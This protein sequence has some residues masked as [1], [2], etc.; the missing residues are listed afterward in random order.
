MT[1]TRIQRKQLVRQLKDA[2][3][4][5]LYQ[6]TLAVLEYDRGKSIAE[7]ARTLRVHRRSVHRWLE[8]YREAYDPATLVDEARSGRPAHWTDECSEWLH[9]FLR[10]NPIELGYFAANW[11]VP[12]LRDAFELGV[13]RTISND[14]IRRALVRFGYVWKRP[15]Y[16]LEPDPE[17]EKKTKYSSRNTPF[18]RPERLAG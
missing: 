12:L 1:L 13:G 2:R 3:N 9:S 15:R 11:T 5:R 8:T 14:T 6:R 4:A 7:I 10:R 16:V 18:A 17:R